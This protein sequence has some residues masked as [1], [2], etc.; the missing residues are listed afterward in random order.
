MQIHLCCVLV[1]LTMSQ[2]AINLI[3]Y[4]EKKEKVMIIFKLQLEDQNMS[5]FI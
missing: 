1:A 3:D 5:P 4:R 2:C